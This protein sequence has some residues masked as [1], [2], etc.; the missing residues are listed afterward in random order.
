MHN[1]A[2]NATTS[3]LTKYKKSTL[4]LKGSSVKKHCELRQ[5]SMRSHRVSIELT[6][7]ERYKSKHQQTNKGSIYKRH[8]N[9]KDKTD[10]YKRMQPERQIRAAEQKVQNF[11][12]KH[13]ICM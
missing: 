11:T 9:K 5:S 4:R 6:E 13:K 1:K 3:L 7:Q 8:N 2:Q 10:K 12:L